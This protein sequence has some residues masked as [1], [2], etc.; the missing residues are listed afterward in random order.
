MLGSI[1][2]A[3]A[4]QRIVLTLLVALGLL[5]SRSRQYWCRDRASQE[6]PSLHKRSLPNFGL[7]HRSVV[8]AIRIS[9]A[10]RRNSVR[11]VILIAAAML[12]ALP[13]FAAV[14]RAGTA[15][16]DIT[17]TGG[18]QL[19]GYEDRVKPATGALDPLYARV[20][21]LEAGDTRLAIVTLDLGRS[22]GPPA[23]QQLRESARR[24]SK[25]SCLLVTASHT[26]S[27]PVIADEYKNGPPAW[28]RTA[29]DR[30]DH[31]IAD[32]AGALTEVRIGTGTGIAYIGH[33]RLRVNA[34]GSVSWFERNL[35]RVPTAPVDPTVTVLRL[36]RM[37]SSP[38]AIL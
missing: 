6:L 31:A 28:E 36:D 13:S 35:T 16:V 33:N 20:L 1:L 15:K 4:P 11:P 37:D 9:I 23:I 10:R 17:P 7:F 14:L 8:G 38:L 26:H 12:T 3:V 27:A 5:R 34:D 2:K 19:W 30:I 24:C 25:I 22:F 32:A 18:E 21:V 29:L